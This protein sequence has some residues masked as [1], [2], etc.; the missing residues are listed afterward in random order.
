VRD[1]TGALVVDLENDVH[2]SVD[3]QAVSAEVTPR[4][5][6]EYQVSLPVDDLS[7]GECLVRI[8]ATDARGITGWRE[9]TVT[10]QGRSVY[11]PLI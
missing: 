11:L 7:Q 10:K 8:S 4:E 2:V 6:G 5:A 3:G 1:E 9:W